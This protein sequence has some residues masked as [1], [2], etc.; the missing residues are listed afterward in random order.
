VPKL[1]KTPG[2][3]G[4]AL[5]AYDIWKRLSPDQRRALLAHAKRY[6]PVVGAYAARTAKNAAA[7]RKSD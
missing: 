3:V 1:V 6:G 4:L 7:K 2:A 5:T